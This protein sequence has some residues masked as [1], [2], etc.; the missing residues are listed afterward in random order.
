MSYAYGMK[1]QLYDT[2]LTEAQWTILAPFFPTATTGRPRRHAYRTIVNAIFYEL[3]SGCPWRLL[4]R[5][6]PAWRTVYHY[7]RKWRLDGTWHRIQTA[8]REQVRQR[9]GRHA[10]PSASI[11]DSQSVKTTSVGGPRGYD[12]GKKITGRKRHLLVD[13]QGLILR[14]VV[15]TADI[16]DRAGVPLVLRGAKEEFPRIEHVWVDQGYTG[17]GKAWIEEHL[18]WQVE[19]VA[20]PPRRKWMV[21]AQGMIEKVVV[22]TGFTPLPH[23]WIVERTHSWLGQNRRLS[24]D[25]ERQCAT[26]EAWIAVAMIRLM[27]R[28]LAPSEHPMHHQ[29]A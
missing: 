7:F 2:D 5:D 27:V 18:G 11:L 17:S 25:F 4:P 13:T 14:A 1:M 12:G 29:A 3:R 16:P 23:R 8:L 15:H 24:K 6:F 9:S 21:D 10:Q 22:R 26:S 19:V 28:R 20:L